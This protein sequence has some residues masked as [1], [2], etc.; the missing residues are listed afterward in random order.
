MTFSLGPKSRAELKGVHMN[1]VRLVYRAIEITEQDFCVYDGARTVEQQREYFRRGVSKTMSSRHLVQKDGLGHAVDLVP[2]IN[3]RA[4][5][6]W[7]WTDVPVKDRPDRPNGPGPAYEIAA[8]CSRAARELGIE[9]VWG[10]VW[11]R[12]TS[13]YDAT[14]AGMARE[15]QAYKARH[16]GTDFLDAPHFELA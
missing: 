14:A 16:A 13:A 1:V 4:V 6:A 15:V 2:W 5:W 9:I 12:R 10:G 3:G 7:G 8:A 11:D